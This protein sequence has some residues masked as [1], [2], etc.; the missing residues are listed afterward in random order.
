MGRFITADE[1][2]STGQGLNGNNMF[3][4]CSNNPVLLSD[5]DGEFGVVASF[6]LGGAMGLISQY[7]SGVV[8]NVLADGMQASD[9][10]IKE[11]GTVGDYAAA[12]ISGAFGSLPISNKLVS[13]AVSVVCDIG[14]P[15]L[16]QIID[17]STGKANG[18]NQQ[19]FIEDSLTNLASDF[20][21]TV[22][23]SE[24]PEPRYLRDIKVSAK[25]AGARGTNELL[26]YLAKEQNNYFIGQQFAD[27]S[28]STM[29]TV[30]KCGWHNIR[31]MMA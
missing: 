30:Y 20:V 7:V 14:A 28:V 2:P 9:F 26:A 16:Q 1:Y 17:I 5:S 21:L 10:S 8:E 4:Y 31:K 6:L 18:W 27:F 15:A 13:A 23:Y 12:F 19:K 24:L 22:A 11:A 3:A 29:A 25:N